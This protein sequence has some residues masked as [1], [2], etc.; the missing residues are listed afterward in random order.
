M[1]KNFRTPLA[2]LIPL[3][4]ALTNCNGTDE[5]NVPACV[6]GY[7]STN[8]CT[9]TA[10][11]SQCIQ[12]SN[13]DGGGD[14]GTGGGSAMRCEVT[15][16]NVCYGYQG[17]GFTESNAQTQCDAMLASNTGA[18]YTNGGCATSNQVGTCTFN[19]GL[20]TEQIVRYYSGGSHNWVCTDGGSQFDAQNNC[21]LSSGTFSC[22]G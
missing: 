13:D 6:P 20:I 1:L 12:S 8:Q 11:C 9:W 22:G 19:S 10:D 21:T 7:D 17:S 14:G 16:L 5:V 4:F 2:L 15:N 18:F 3:A